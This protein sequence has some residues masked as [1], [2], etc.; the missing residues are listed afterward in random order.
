[1]IFS[2]LGV[3][4][5]HQTLTGWVHNPTSDYATLSLIKLPRENNLFLTNL[6]S[7]NNGMDFERLVKTLSFT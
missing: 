5:C 2:K 3:P 7:D 1:M 4:V 6:D